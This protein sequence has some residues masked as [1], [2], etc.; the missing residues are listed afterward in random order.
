[1]LALIMP[2]V[3]KRRKES[4]HFNMKQHGRKLEDC[5]KLGITFQQLHVLLFF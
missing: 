1:M 3:R 4:N 5:I 2:S